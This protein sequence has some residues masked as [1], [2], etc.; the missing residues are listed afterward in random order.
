MLQ[1]RQVFTPLNSRHTPL[2]LSPLI[3]KM[4][5]F[6][7]RSPEVCGEVL[8]YTN[9]TSRRTHRG[10]GINRFLTDAKNSDWYTSVHPLTKQRLTIS[11]ILM[12]LPTRLRPLK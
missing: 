9:S 2:I 11:K 12:C 10:N 6:V 4:I 5:C 1:R 3:V 8:H 7:S